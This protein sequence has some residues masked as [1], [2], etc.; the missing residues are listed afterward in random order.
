MSA[1]FL[2]HGIG[3]RQDLP[4]PLD[5]LVQ[6]A[7]LALLASFFGLGVLWRSP[8]LRA[9]AAGWALPDAI[10]RIVDGAALRWLLRG[11]GLL[12]TAYVLVTALAAPSDKNP[13]PYVVYVLFWVGMVPVSLLLGPVWRRINPL[14]TIHLLLAAITRIP[15]DRGL[16]ALPE[17]LGYWPAVASLFGFVWLELAA[18]DRAAV[19]V[20][21]W[22]FACYVLIHLSAALLFGQRWF[23]TGEGFEV[24]F[25]VIATLAP[26]GRRD[27][28]RLVLRNPLDGV[29]TLGSAPGIV[30]L[31]GV[32]LGAT[33]FD[34][35]SGSAEWGLAVQRLPVSRVVIATA[36]L[37]V[38][39]GVV[40]LTFAGATALAG[41][42]G[43]RGRRSVPGLLAHTIVPIVAGYVIAH[44]FS[45]L[46]FE[47][48]QAIALL[49]DPLSARPQISGAIN[50]GLVTATGIALVQVIAVVIGHI[51]AVISAHDRS[52]ALFP[53]ADAIIGQ[54]PLMVLMVGYTVGGLT[55][56]FAA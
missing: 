4:L 54:L 24:Y 47:G 25:T 38:T 51:L 1:G 33:F 20:L 36:G 41:R 52:V 46:I 37:L 13:L 48:Q 45:F 7:V 53:K 49:T 3:A 8:R 42:A 35:I 32:L 5:L 18:P 22:Y 6:G 19:P 40:A 23:A 15:A 27:D 29:A 31:V 43:D 44:Y 34:T 2:A 12:A 16:R 50:Y 11:L 26:L 14:R 39:I 55:L 10:Q 28:G 9:G 30:A 21:L 56:L 17:W